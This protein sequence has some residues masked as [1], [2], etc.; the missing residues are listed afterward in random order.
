MGKRRRCN[1]K[2]LVLLLTTQP[3]KSIGSPKSLISQT[4]DPQSAADQNSE[5]K[6]E[7]ETT[8]GAPEEVENAQSEQEEEP[9]PV[10]DSPGAPRS[11][12][13]MVDADTPL[14]SNHA[15]SSGTTSVRKSIEAVL[16]QTL[17]ASHQVK[18][19]SP[20]QVSSSMNQVSSS[21]N[22]ALD[23]LKS[24]ATPYV[25]KAVGSK[26]EGGIPDIMNT[27]TG[28]S[29]GDVQSGSGTS[30]SMPTSTADVS[31]DFDVNELAEELRS[32][33][34]DKN[35]KAETTEYQ[36]RNKSRNSN[37]R[38]PNTYT[39]Y[40]TI[41]IPRPAALQDESA[42][43]PSSNLQRPV[44]LQVS[45]RTPSS[46]HTPLPPLT[47]AELVSPSSEKIAPPSSSGQSFLTHAAEVSARAVTPIMRMRNPAAA[48]QATA[49]AKVG[50]RSRSEE[51]YIALKQK[52]W[53]QKM[54][55]IERQ[56]DEERSMLEDGVDPQSRGSRRSRRRGKS[57]TRG[58]QGG[59]GLD[60]PSCQNEITQILER[61]M[62][63]RCGS[64]DDVMYDDDDSLGESDWSDSDEDDFTASG[65]EISSIGGSARVIAA[66]S[67]GRTDEPSKEQR[68]VGDFGVK[69]KNFIKSFISQLSK[70]GM[71]LMLHKKNSGK[72]LNDGS[73][74]VVAS[75]Q[76]GAPNATREFVAP[77]FVW[78]DERG[79]E[80]G[81][82]D[83]FDIASLD[84]ATL[85]QLSAYPL[86]MPGRSLFLRL[87]GGDVYVF[88]A[89]SD[90]DALRFIHGM[91]WVIAR[92]TF[93]LIIGNL[94]VSCELLD[95][96]RSD[97]AEGG[98]AGKFPKT[99]KEEANW[100]KAMNDVT[101]HLVD[102]ADLR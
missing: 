61:F 89:L 18:L 16:T 11:P 36:P 46:E 96:E 55:I 23:K 25:S 43:P 94:S 75:I 32:K 49:P 41:G 53:K 74:K 85:L 91:R 62:R 33:K 3:R 31:D 97:D 19:P 87:N 58:A 1:P 47:A 57:R 69:D 17:N 13:V 28:S 56:R 78:K 86:A 20:D 76:R 59:G 92:L 72:S 48:S 38:S 93:N 90:D 79:D 6:K 98:D 29:N 37:I 101:S 22:Q 4:W 21:M 8:T 7:G 27:S 80:S 50:T 26:E 83:L 68:Q 60:L 88:E 100:T 5:E 45:S 81:E 66:E 64:M 51:E 15:A 54:R 12:P 40:D 99:L 44:P 70:T 67:R 34:T 30:S 9:K 63:N 24:F 10:D 14:I 95:V 65:S 42:P 2:R 73:R 35:D 39:S 52:K 82:I 102:K 71:E 84:K 77:K